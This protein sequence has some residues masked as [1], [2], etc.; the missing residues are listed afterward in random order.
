[1]RERLVV[2]WR[3]TEACNLGCA[4]CKYDQARPFPRKSADASRAL[5]IGALL[6]EHQRASGTLVHVS[7]LGGEPLLWPPFAEVVPTFHAGLGLSIGVTTNGTA[8]ASE[9]MLGCVLEHVDELTLSIDGFAELHDRLRG[10]AGGFARLERAIRALAAEKRRRGRGPLLRANVV[11][12]R[13]NAAD[14]PALCRVLA[15]FGIEEITFNQLGGNDRP[16]FFAE[17]RLLVPDVE[18]LGA[19]IE[20][21]RAELDREGVRLRGPAAYLD[22][23]RASASGR[24]LPIAD[25]APGER[26]LFL[27]ENGLVAPC[28]FTA[29]TLGL[30]IGS[31]GIRAL[32]QDFRSARIRARP[33]I[34][35]DC[36]STQV[37]D[38]F[39]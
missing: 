25:C 22:R 36:P 21:L 26:F 8:L 3:V 18:R 7:L 9:R 32:S 10:W 4:F 24:R 11:L 23:F 30:P 35:G 28:S 14:F 16:E 15:G 19:A 29:E 34:C 2:V 12:M 13:D 33:A 17:H 27:D 38:K 39:G 20:P 5:E 37:F 6:S 31:R 1:V